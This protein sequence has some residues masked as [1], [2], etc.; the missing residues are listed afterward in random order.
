M[1]K[2]VYVIGLLLLVCTIACD[3][4][5]LE[6]V[7]AST[8]IVTV[9]RDHKDFRGVVFNEVGDVLL[10]QGP[11]YSVKLTGPDNVV[12]L[13]ESLVDGEVLIIGGEN[14]YN[15]DYNLKIEIT[16]PEFQYIA[17]AGIGKMK[18]VGA[19]E[20]DVIQVEILGIGDIEANF[21]AD[22]LYTKI[23]GTADIIYS[24]EVFYHEINS[25]GDYELSAF[26][27]ETQ[28][29]SITFSGT[30]QNYVTA[31]QN[32]YVKIIGIGDVH[33]Q[34]NPDIESDISGTGQIIDS[35]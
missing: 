13:T 30:G 21:I 14:C 18:T 35:N 25:T 29:T 33:Y 27:L 31:Y 20:S 34:G 26:A 4:N 1:K 12:E 17:L 9:E 3:T 11:E 2:F 8:N 15:G 5:Q 24:G 7:R 10:T 19:L 22:T 6:C 32:L 16:A 28:N 23:S